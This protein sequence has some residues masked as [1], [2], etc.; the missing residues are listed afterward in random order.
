MSELPEHIRA[1]AA[2]APSRDDQLSELRDKAREVRDLGQTI[3]D[4]EQLVAE[5]RGRHGRLLREVLPEMMD[6]AGVAS[7]ELQ[8]EGNSPGLSFKLQ[9]FFSAGI[10]ASWPADK[11][12]AA[13]DYL[14]SIGHGDLIKTF[15]TLSFPREERDA[16]LAVAAEMRSRDVDVEVDESVHA[17]TLK[18]WLRE[19]VDSGD[20]PDLDKIGG[21]VGR[22]VVI[23]EVKEKK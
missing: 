10:A 3:A 16:A 2:G 12:A 5:M 23:K 18:A 6:A 21:S 17:S 4:N 15:V 14:T 22:H 1:A 13:L 11:K 9:P 7:L 20:M 8:P 19:M